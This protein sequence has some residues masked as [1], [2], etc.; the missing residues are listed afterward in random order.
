MSPGGNLR[1]L[2]WGTAHTWGININFDR[3]LRI[4][5]DLLDAYDVS[6]RGV[7]WPTDRPT[8][9]HPMVHQVCT[10]NFGY[11]HLAI[12][13]FTTSRIHVSRRTVSKVGLQF[14]QSSASYSWRCVHKILAATRRR[15]TGQQWG[16]SER[17]SCHWAFLWKDEGI[18]IT[19]NSSM[20]QTHSFDSLVGRRN[21]LF[22]SGKMIDPT[23]REILI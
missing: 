10:I 6:G 15:A 19:T 5:I 12:M 3:V 18:F 23:N 7:L 21:R 17:R 1:H 11:T 14:C 2:R 22:T 20:F 4:S 13:S 16:I 8:P 9:P